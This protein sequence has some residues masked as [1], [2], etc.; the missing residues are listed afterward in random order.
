[1]PQGSLETSL[2]LTFSHDPSNYNKK[3]DEQNGGSR[4]LSAT[5]L[6]GLHILFCHLVRL[7][8]PAATHG[9]VEAHQRQE[10]GPLCLG[11]C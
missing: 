6:L 3:A 7:D 8:D 9:F 11:K 5:L 4:Y 10:E 1:M 2:L